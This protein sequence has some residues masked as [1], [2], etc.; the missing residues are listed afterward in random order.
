VVRAQLDEA[1]Y[2]V[3][4][5]MGRAMTVEQAIADAVQAATGSGGAEA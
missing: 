4:W 1:T 5:S 3:A 2:R